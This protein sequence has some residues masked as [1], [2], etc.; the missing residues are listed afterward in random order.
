[1]S[2]TFVIRKIAYHYSDDHLYVHTIGGIENTFQSEDEAKTEFLRLEREAL[3][4]CDLGDTAQLSGCDNNY[5][6]GAI[7][8]KHYYKKKFGEDIVK[9][10]EYG[11][12][13]CDRGTTIPKGLSDDDILY[14][15]K[16]LDLK[17]YELSS[18]EGSPVFYGIWLNET[19]SFF[20]YCEVP[21]FFSTYAEALKMA[22]E[23]QNFNGKKL[24]GSLEELS[25]NPIF[26]KS[27][28]NSSDALDYDEEK[29][30]LTIKYPS[31]DVLMALNELL[32]FKVF[33]IKE[34]P[35]A[36]V[37]NIEHWNYE[38]M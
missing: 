32:K 25:T 16:I 8:F 19:N 20:E 9:V 1:M 17:F 23:Y 12:V 37:E 21:Y 6:K 2:K 7:E 5:L 15:R 26:L 22:K 33:E 11:T 38:Q 35:I 31:K 4:S 10:N 24:N 36:L 13:Y 34:I 14:I 30:V 28:I 3:E 18:F 29:M 27:L